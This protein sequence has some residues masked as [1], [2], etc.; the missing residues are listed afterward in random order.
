MRSNGDWQNQAK[1]ILIDMKKLWKEK[2]K[3][4]KIAKNIHR[5]LLRVSWIKHKQTHKS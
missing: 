3:K 5:K 4:I 2:N 1:H